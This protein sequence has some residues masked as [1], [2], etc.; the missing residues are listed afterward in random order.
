[1]TT[2]AQ[3]DGH[4]NRRSTRTYFVLA[5]GTLSW[6]Q[7]YSPG[8]RGWETAGRPEATTRLRLLR[9]FATYEAES[10]LLLFQELGY[11]SG[12]YEPEVALADA[13]TGLQKAAR[14]F[15]RKAVLVPSLWHGQNALVDSSPHG[16]QPVGV[17]RAG[18][19]DPDTL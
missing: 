1:V 11:V 6:S 4:G 16:T 15:F 12:E 19:D 2:K 9:G 13:G 18:G 10:W 7:P 14:L 8:T 17:P 3:S 5:A